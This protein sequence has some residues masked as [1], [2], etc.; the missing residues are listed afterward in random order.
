MRLSLKT[1]A[2][3]T[4]MTACG[5]DSP[6]APTAP[7]APPPPPVA[8]VEVSPQSGS[9]YSGR[10]LQLTAV[11]KAANG[12]TLSDR[13]VTWSSSNTAVASVSDAGVVS[14]ATFGPATI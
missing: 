13:R 1:A 12:T 9:L 2:V 8:I 4:L 3:A 6:S 10:S 5:G 11:A 14:A 7:A